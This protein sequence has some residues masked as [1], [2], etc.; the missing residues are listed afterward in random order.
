M[1]LFSQLLPDFAEKAK[2]AV[3]KRVNIATRP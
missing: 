3:N 2:H 1:S